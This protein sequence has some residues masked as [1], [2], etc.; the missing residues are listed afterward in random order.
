M[1]GAIT[2]PKKG[3]TCSTDDLYL[4]KLL[5]YILLHLGQVTNKFNIPKHN[6]NFMQRKKNMETS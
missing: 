1:G 6:F 5:I 2:T 3:W 4:N